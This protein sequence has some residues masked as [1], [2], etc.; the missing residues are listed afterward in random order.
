MQCCK[1]TYVFK[2]ETHTSNI[3]PFGSSSF[4][5]LL[6]TPDGLFSK[7]FL[8][9]WSVLWAEGTTQVTV[10]KTSILWG[11]PR[12]SDRKFKQVDTNREHTHAYQS[13]LPFHWLDAGDRQR[14]GVWRGSEPWGA[15]GC[16]TKGSIYLGHCN[17]RNKGS[18]IYMNTHVQWIS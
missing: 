18:F 5:L 6:I 3:F 13:H 2:L 8:G 7:F 10:R 11:S 4:F 1:S 16:E 14:P 9:A 17:S 12:R 15:A